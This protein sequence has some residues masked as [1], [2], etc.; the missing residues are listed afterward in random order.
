MCML[1]RFRCHFRLVD[2][3]GTEA[4]F[5]YKTDHTKK[6]IYG[7]HGLNLKQYNT[8][9]RKCH[10]VDRWTAPSRILITS[11]IHYIVQAE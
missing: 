8:M 10:I 11:G 6:N 5:N 3:F 7:Y 1:V 4:Q 2:S 9:F